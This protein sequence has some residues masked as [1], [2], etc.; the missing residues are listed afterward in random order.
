M[1]Q[2]MILNVATGD[3]L[4]F[5]SFYVSEANQ[6]LLALLSAFSERSSDGSQMFVWGESH[7]GKTQSVPEQKERSAGHTKK[8]IILG[9][10]VFGV[11]YNTE[12]Y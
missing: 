6:D 9:I 8:S 7:S 1:P 12:L 4:S 10:V 11:R 5:E 2:Q 3:A